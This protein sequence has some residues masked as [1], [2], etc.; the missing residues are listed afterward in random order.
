LKEPNHAVATSLVFNTSFR[1]I[2]V[3]VVL[4]FI[5]RM[6]SLLVWCLQGGP[7]K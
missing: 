7:K 1:C 2:S 3:S 6:F 4:V 5:C